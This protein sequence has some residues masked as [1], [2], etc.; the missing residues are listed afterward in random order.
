MY[1]QQLLAISM[2]ISRYVIV[3][4]LVACAS[5]LMAAGDPAG[6]KCK[7]KEFENTTWYG[8][9]KF[10]GGSTFIAVMHIDEVKNCEVKGR[11]HWPDFFNTKTEFIGNYEDGVL[12][13]RESKIYQGVI[14]NLDNGSHEI[15]LSG[16][17]T[18]SGIAFNL[19]NEVASMVLFNQEHLSAEALVK[20][21]AQILE[22][23]KKYGV[24]TVGEKS[25][26]GIEELRQKIEK[27]EE[28]LDADISITGRGMFSGIEL[29]ITMM[30]SKTGKLYLEMNFMGTSFR[31]GKNDSI[32]W[33]YD[34]TSDKVE[35][36]SVEREA[37]DMNPFANS[38]GSDWLD[39]IEIDDIT[40]VDIDGLEAYRIS[41]K[42]DSDIN[43]LYFSKNEF[44][45]VRSKKGLQV[46][47]FL[48][49]K[50][51]EGMSIFTKYR[52]ISLQGTVNMMYLDE[53]EFVGKIED[54]LFDVPEE[55]KTKVIQE[56]STSV[57]DVAMEAFDKEEFERAIDLYTQAIK[58]SAYDHQ[59]YYMRGRARYTLGNYY[60][61]LGDMERAIELND[62]YADYFNYRG[63]IKYALT[64]YTNAKIDFQQSIRL[65]S[66]GY[67]GY[68]NCAFATFQ[69]EEYDSTIAYLDRGIVHNPENPQLILNRGVTHFQVNHYQESLNDYRHILKLEYG[70][71]GETVNRMGVAFYGLEQYDSAT[72]YFSEA[73]ELSPDNFQRQK[74]LGDSYYKLDSY[75]EAIQSYRKAQELAE[76]PNATL[77]NDLAMSYYHADDYQTALA[78]LNELIEVNS[79]NASYFDN[80]A[81]THAAVMDYQ[82]AIKDFSRSIDLYSTDN[83]IYYQRGLLYKLQNNRFD[84]CRDFET[85][86]EMEHEEAGAELKEYCT[87]ATKEEDN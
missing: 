24:L 46:K 38:F 49:Y 20:Y 85:A 77:L 87:M 7:L 12:K 84:A 57:Q 44:Q 55:L 41:Y 6:K 47:E 48:D 37:G 70:D 3:L 14:N 71:R 35:V 1:K 56:T 40:D 36:K 72:L 4:L 45:P 5:L 15:K 8:E 10:Y 50:S 59:S 83:E 18:L 60:K 58:Q 74:N 29:P 79:E 17:D 33:S 25:D 31:M 13:A 82:N 73:V 53:I 26:I 19:G 64:D 32:S 67:I 9:F 11:F 68:L 75:P 2:R 62:Q 21:R 66:T 54:K 78:V 16:S 63:L 61:A 76:E 42:E 86:A 23:E 28:D 80:R 22:M 39:E 43:A 34:P 51:F 69:L 27:R 30:V 65:D 81:Y 52:D